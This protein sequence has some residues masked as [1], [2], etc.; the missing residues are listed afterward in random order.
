VWKQGVTTADG[1][2]SP[3]WKGDVL[4]VGAGLVPHPAILATTAATL[5][6]SATTEKSSSDDDEEQGKPLKLRLVF[7]DVD[8]LRQANTEDLERLSYILKDLQTAVLLK[9]LTT[10][11]TA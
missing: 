8:T 1:I 6:T 4:D 11:D 9:L 10:A 3:P 5:A 7:K 2:Q